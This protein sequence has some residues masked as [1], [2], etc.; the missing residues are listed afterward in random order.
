MSLIGK[1]T[2]LSLFDRPAPKPQRT[3]RTDAERRADLRAH[4]ADPYA[5]PPKRPRRAKASIPANVPGSPLH[6]AP[7]S[8][9]V[10]TDGNF[11]MLQPNK[12]SWLVELNGEFMGSVKRG[13]PPRRHVNAIPYNGWSLDPNGGEGGRSGQAFP[14]WRVL[15]CRRAAELLEAHLKA[16]E[17]RGAESGN[18]SVELAAEPNPDFTHSSYSSDHRGSVSI[19][20]HRVPVTSYL[21]ASSVV[22]QFITKN[23]LGGGNWTG[24]DIRDAS[25]KVIGHVSYNGRVWDRP[26][27]GAKEI[28]G[29]S[30]E[31]YRLGGA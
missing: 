27:S 1:P 22:Q 28:R 13:A 24:G 26:G 17:S 10:L 2:S 12:G 7:Y 25:G 29:S 20:S 23:E 18:W 6:I 16:K 21:E 15:V 11:M 30:D 9:K 3:Q 8:T 31:M 19:R 4:M 14:T 5:T